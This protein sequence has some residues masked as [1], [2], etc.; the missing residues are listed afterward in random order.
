MTGVVAQVASY[1][2]NTLEFTEHLRAPILSQ[3]FVEAVCMPPFCT[4]VGMKVNGTPEF[5]DLNEA[6]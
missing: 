4:P 5:S 2:S 1:H 6:M 3:V